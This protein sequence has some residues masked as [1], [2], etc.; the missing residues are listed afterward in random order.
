VSRTNSLRE[1]GD[2]F[3]A[4]FSIPSIAAYDLKRKPD[5]TEE[6]SVPALQ[7][8]VRRLLADASH[9]EAWRPRRARS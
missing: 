1:S 5:A 7:H 3:G 4:E 9:G 2:A 8:S 6:G